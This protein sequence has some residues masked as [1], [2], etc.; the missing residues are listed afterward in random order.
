MANFLTNLFSAGA[1][2]LVSAIGDSIDKVVTS[3]EERLSLEN[4]IAKAEMNYDIEKRTLKLEETKAYLADTDSARDNQSRVQE[5]EHASWLSKN[6]HPI[7][8]IS[9][10]GLTFGMYWWIIG[11]D[12]VKF[13]AHGMRDIIIFILGSLATL[14]TQ[15][16]SYFF[17]SSQGSADKNK[18]L[19]KITEKNPI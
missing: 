13:K 19:S 9:I 12:A 4:E 11:L 5:S 2:S 15:V 1:T 6:V 14:S 10:L 8:A 7:L 18:T 16:A 3:D 17:G